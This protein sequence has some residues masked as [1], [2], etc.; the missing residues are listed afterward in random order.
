MVIIKRTLGDR[1][2]DAV[3]ALLLTFLMIITLYPLLYV[4]FASLSS[5]NELISHTGLLLKPQGFTFGAY[6]AVLKNPM[7]FSGYKNTLFIVIVGTVYNIVMTSMGAYVLSRKKFF[8]KKP[9]T[10]MVIVTMFFG[11]GLIPSYLLI[12]NLGL[13][14]KLWALIIPS[15]IGT[16]NL[17]IMR[18]SF[19]SIPDSLIES[20]GMDGANEFTILFKIVLPLSLPTIAVMALYYGVGHWNSWFNAM[21]YLRKREL[22]PLQLV[23][24]EILIS[25]STNDMMQNVAVTEKEA[26]SETIKYATIMVATVPILCAYPFLQKY[27]V[28]GA[29]V[30]AL[31]G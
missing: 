5:P 6:K 10:Y 8:W 12:Q 7:I 9:M 21:I 17:I 23:L 2:F 13:G 28:K 30:G 27:F 18:T 25:N 15:A 11:G 29:M 22:Y 31:K 24:R 4:V 1:I 20:A 16:W 14:N 3:N 19:A 26:I